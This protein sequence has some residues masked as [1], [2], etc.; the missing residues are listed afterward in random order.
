MSSHEM[1]EVMRTLTIATV[2]FVPLT[3]LTGYFVRLLLLPSGPFDLTC[4]V[5]PGYELQ[6]YAVRPEPFRSLLLGDRDPNDDRYYHL[7]LLDGLWPDGQPPEE[8]DT[9]QED[10]QG[11]HWTPVSFLSQSLHDR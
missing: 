5:C 9:E 11:E 6:C 8:D 3:L 7:I 1:N 2:L 4:N 10:R